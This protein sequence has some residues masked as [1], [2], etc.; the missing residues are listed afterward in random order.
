M[1]LIQISLVAIFTAVAHSQVGSQ[2][3]I[4]NIDSITDLSSQ[5]NDV[6]Q[7]ISFNN[8]FSTA[9][10]NLQVP[11]LRPNRWP[12]WQMLI[13]DFRQII[14]FASEDIA[15]MGNPTRRKTKRELLDS[16]QARRYTGSV[17]ARAASFTT[18]QKRQASPPYTETNQLQICDAFREACCYFAQI[19]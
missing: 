1:M 5:T 9:P 10:V 4:D 16:E 15:S 11:I 12:L 2:D 6:A 3:L 17:T 8:V 18:A 14:Q 7:S 19:Y 13:D